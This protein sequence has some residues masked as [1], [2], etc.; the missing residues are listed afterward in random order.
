MGQHTGADATD[1][2]WLSVKVGDEHEWMEPYGGSLAAVRE[3]L[4]E[5]GTRPPI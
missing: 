1:T 5:L 3:V 2:D 4:S